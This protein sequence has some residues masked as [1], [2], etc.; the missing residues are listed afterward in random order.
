MLENYDL[1]KRQKLENLSEISSYDQAD[2]FE[3]MLGDLSHTYFLYKSVC[4]EFWNKGKESR[5]IQEFVFIN[6]RMAVMYCLK[7]QMAKKPCVHVKKAM[8]GFTN[9]WM[10]LDTESLKMHLEEMNLICEMGKFGSC[11]AVERDSVTVC[12]PSKLYSFLTS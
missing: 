6:E 2:L 5:K 7:R 3:S 4:V 9:D 8:G 1:P 10:M 12:P 11:Y